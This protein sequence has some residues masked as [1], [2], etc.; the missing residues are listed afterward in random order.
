ML[1]FQLTDLAI[2]HYFELSK[3]DAERAL[4]IYKG[5]ASQ[6]G[7]VIKFLTIARQHEMSTRLPVPRLKHAPLSLAKSLE[8]YLNDPDFDINRRQFLAQ[9]EARRTGKKLPT[10][11]ATAKVAN[12]KATSASP[13]QGPAVPAKPVQA[14]KGPAPDLIDFFASIESNQESMFGPQPPAQPQQ[15]GFQPG[16]QQMPM[17]TGQMAGY[18]QQGM[19]NQ[20]FQQDP[21]AAQFSGMNLGGYGTQPNQQPVQAFAP[22]PLQAAQS[23][24]F[25]GLQPQATG[26]M[27]ASTGQQQQTTNPFRQ[28]IMPP[29]AQQMP[30]PSQRQSTNPFA[31][32]Q[33]TGMQS[34]TEHPQSSFSQ[35]S[36]P[37]SFSQQQAYQQQPAMM[38]PQAPMQFPPQPAAPLQSM[39]T[40]TN[41]F[42]R[43]QTGTPQQHGLASP[44]LSGGSA[45]AG[46]MPQPTGSTNPFRAS[47]MPAG[48]ATLGGMQADHMSTIPVFPRPGQM[49]GQQ[50]QPF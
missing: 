18:G 22:N 35:P 28:S 24:D 37:Q 46:L 29:G 38:S 11:T 13:D 49:Q 10:N 7:R 2:E 34:L 21:M 36:I 23:N 9:L 25:G 39:Q 17:M 48:Q 15:T 40:G 32:P 44:P 6:T 31:K 41:P 43:P 45:G 26:M 42:A 50:R 12:S 47:M 14:A 3:T 16:M 30:D 19:P 4:N 27:S 5:F 8:D 1:C 33:M 20:T